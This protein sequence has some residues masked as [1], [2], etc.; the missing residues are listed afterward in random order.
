MANRLKEIIDKTRRN[1]NATSLNVA[2]GNWEIDLMNLC[3][4]GRPWLLCDRCTI[5]A[6]KLATI[7]EPNMDHYGFVIVAQI[8]ERF[9]HL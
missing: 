9:P 4:Y 2:L 8:K 5:L 6:K 3:D 7:R 1:D